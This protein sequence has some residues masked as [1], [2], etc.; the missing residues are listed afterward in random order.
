[1]IEIRK[2]VSKDAQQI[3][4]VMADAERSGFMMFSPGERQMSAEGTAK[5]IDNMNNE[6]KSGLFVAQEGDAILGYMVIRGNNPER[7]AHRAYLVIGIHS[8]SRGKG[9]GK[10]L[11]SFIIDWAKEQGL[12]RLDLTV[13]VKNTVAVN[14]Y[15]KMGFE[16]EGVKK[17]SLYIDGQYEDEYY[18]AKL[19]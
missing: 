14:L 7:I 16:I 9:V 17:H 5:W 11:F 2:A 10:A 12:H 13:L 19:L 15:K 3:I 6:L 4:K 18:M 8:D 1:M